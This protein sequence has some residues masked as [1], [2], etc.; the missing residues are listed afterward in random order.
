MPASRSYDPRPSYPPVDGKVLAG[1]AAPAAELPQGPVVL[2]VDGPAALDWEALTDGLTRALRSADRAVDLVDVRAHYARNAGA[3]MAAQPVPSDDPF[4]TPLSQADVRDLFDS[5]PQPERP[6]QDGVVMVYGP[7]ASLCEPDVLWYADLPK[8]YA[9]AAVANGDPTVGVNLG[10]PDEP[11]DLVRL[12]YTDWP[13]LDRHR[14]AIAHRVDRWIDTQDTDSPASL[15]GAALRST[16]A[17]LARG[18]VRTRPYFNSTPWGGQWAAGELGF[19]PQAGNTALGYEL[20][21]PEAGVLVGEKDGAQ[22]EIP[23]QL[24]CAEHPEAMLGDDVHRRFGTSFPIRFDYLDTMGGGNLSLHLH[25]REQYMRD[26]FGWPYTQHETYYV[27]ASED[28]AEVLLGLTEDADVDT[29]RRQVEDAIGQGTAMPVRDHVQ[30]HPATVGQLFMIPAGTPHAS[31]AGNLVLEVS[32]TPYLY[33]LRFYDWL[34]KDSSGASR[35]LPYEHGFANLDTARRGEDVRKD[36]VQHPRTLRSGEGW[37]EEVIGELPEMFYAVHRLVLTRNASAPDDTAGRFHILNVAA[38]E[39][40]VIE[41][42]D[43]R[44]HSLAFAETIT[45]PAAVGPYRLRAVGGDEVRIV[46]A[47]VVE[48]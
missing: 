33:S 31:G 9:E 16:L 40:A 37:H 36:L 41:T 7:G 26:V 11:G 2:A 6:S 4:F 47:L 44:T 35:P 19:T 28:G 20:I 39:G 10:Q 29:M 18:P 14:D 25:P 3:R 5:F 15:A 12:F 34:R 24:L 38:G 17:H 1:W 8:R 27:T 48:P 42:H 43:G 30:S 22:V 13:V 45:I 46:K 32:A 21:A 23:F